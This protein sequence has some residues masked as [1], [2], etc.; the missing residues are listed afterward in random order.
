MM[1]LVQSSLVTFAMLLSMPALA[2]APDIVDADEAM[3]RAESVARLREVAGATRSR[4]IRFRACEIQR[5]ERMPPTF[6]Y[7][8]DVKDVR[9]LDS[10]C[11]SS[12][13]RA[14]RLPNIDYYTSKACRDAIERRRK[15]LAY[16]AH[17]N[18]Q[19]DALR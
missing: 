17:E 15:D 11:L 3:F 13:Q 10:L 14:E 7:S 9:A 4:L 8:H 12:S 19:R 5:R 6:C 18:D 2:A 16:V 1:M